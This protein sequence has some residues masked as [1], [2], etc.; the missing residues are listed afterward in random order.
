MKGKKHLLFDADNTLY[1]FGATEKTALE[2]LFAEYS[3]PE[4]LLPLY[5]EGNRRCWEM[6]EHGEIT[7]EELETKR[8]RLFFDAAGID[9]DPEKAGL[10]YSEYLGE[11]GIMIP[12]AVS[13]LSEL[14][15]RYTLSLITNG[16]AKVQR[17]RIKRTD[18]GKFFSN[19]F[20]S[21][22][23]GYAKPDRRFFGFVL[24][25]L[26][27]EKE[28]CLVIGDSLTSD[29]KGAA[30]SG[31]DS[32]FI[33]FSGKTSDEAAYSVKSYAELSAL[34]LDKE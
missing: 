31:I 18:T 5:H 14:Q 21:Q 7:L 32:V 8:F 11:A 29:I 12:G 30:D 23:I 25:A 10:E 3:L 33:S 17:E 15:G 1:D 6:Y 28:E 26:S 19:I 20:I 4:T 24:R 22:E 16:I 27:A 34:L 13:F 9:A 2:R